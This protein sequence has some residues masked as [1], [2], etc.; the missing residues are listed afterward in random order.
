MTVVTRFAPSP[1][2]FLHIGGARTALFN[3]LYARHHGGRFLLRIEDTDRARSTDA[4]M[5]A[6][7]DGLAWL[8]LDW[9]GDWVSQFQRRDRHAEVAHRLLDEGKAY[10]CYASQDELAEMRA[11]AKAEGRPMRYDGR[12]RDRDPAEAP[13]GVPPVVRLKAPQTGET[14]LDD[15]V[16][17]EV[18]VR[19]D[20][21]DDFVLL[22]ADGTPTYMLSVVVDD[23]DMGI[24]HVIRGDDHLTNA[25]RQTQLYHAMGVDAPVWAH[26]PLIHGPDGAK[27]SKRHGALGVDAYRDMGYLPEALR[28]YLLRLGWGHGDDEIITTEQA[29]AWFDLDAV[30]KGAARFDFAK[31]DHL[32]GYYLRE[33]ADADL[34]AAVEDRLTA[35]LGRALTA[36]DRARV[37]AGMA[38]LKARAKNLNDLAENAAFYCRHRPLAMTDKA[39]GLLD[40][41]AR[42]LLRHVAGA[43]ADLAT[44]DEPSV[45]ATVRLIAD[46]RQIKLGR[47]A[48]PLRA[49]LTGSAVSPGVFEVAAVLGRDETLGR[50]ADAAPAE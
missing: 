17:G 48:Q 40:A 30:G 11:R 24:T 32:N 37:S 36:E 28:N 35:L 9:D 47:I 6:I 19:N 27:L 25:V 20:Q 46:E 22:R 12:W 15:R 8:G 5:D 49:A 16:Q 4:A 38:G 18:R 7:L 45:E 23:V 1:T 29:V 50:I 31:L 13:A 43:L 3:W 14:V 21:L 41:E 42:D 44:W 33:S 34:V 10:H 26:I 39:A 2:G